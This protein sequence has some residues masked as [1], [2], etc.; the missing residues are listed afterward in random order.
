[1][2]VAVVGHHTWFENH[3]PENWRADPDLLCLDVDERDYSWLMVLR[4]FKP[5]ITLFY[6]PE[7][8][9]EAY[10]RHVSGIRVAI[11]SEPLPVLAENGLV[12]TDE[13]AL[14]MT[15][16][17]RMAWHAYHWRIYYDPGKQASAG[18]LGLP[19]EEFRPMP[20]DTSVFAPL[21]ASVPRSI[22]VCFMGKPTA[23]RI[24]A[25]DALRL[26]RLRFVWVAHGLS[27]PELARLFARS[28]VV[29]NIHADAMPALEP[30]LYLAAACGCRVVTEP[31]SSPP[32]VFAR[33]IFEESRPLDEY[34]LR[35]HVEAQQRQ[36]WTALDENDR[37]SLS[38]R[39][40]IA[41]I[42]ARFYLGGLEGSAA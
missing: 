7:L 5:D 40:L 17:G 32:S 34:V 20:I 22:D 35:P 15:V 37:Q 36:P 38:V 2:R 27:G 6:R 39:R 3:F 28:H 31:L 23:H 18:H 29:L 1:M 42:N 10:L 19:I 8:Y 11:L 33:R 41:D 26:M 12:L 21:P 25:L 13:T 4:N 16:Y 24:A 9:P 30:R 14:R